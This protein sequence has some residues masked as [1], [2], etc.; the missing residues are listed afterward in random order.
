MSAF[1]PL[2]A[3]LAP[4]VPETLREP[5]QPQP[6]AAPECEEVLRAVRRFHAGLRDAVDAAVP[7]LLRAIARDVLARELNLGCAEIR[8]IVRAALEHFG[9][10]R[11]LAVR[12]HPAEI[13]LLRDIA[14]ARIP[15]DDLQPGDIRI[16]LRSGTIDLTLPARLETVLVAWE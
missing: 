7:E 5:P 11:V 2:A 8:P 6:V 16:E 15:D 12:A 10:Q 14:L 1:T 9:S 13:D 3:F 4:K